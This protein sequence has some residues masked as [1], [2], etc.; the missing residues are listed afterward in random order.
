MET[1]GFFLCARQG[2]HLGSERLLL[3]RSGEELA[4]DKSFRREAE[5]RRKSVRQNATPRNTKRIRGNPSGQDD[6]NRDEPE[7]DTERLDCRCVGDERERCAH[8]PGEI[9]SYL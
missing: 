1:W 5:V 9:L 8:V 2:A 7:T 6:I 4:E 3:T